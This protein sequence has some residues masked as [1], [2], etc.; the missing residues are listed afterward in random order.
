MCEGILPGGNL[1]EKLD[2]HD[3]DDIDD[4]GDPAR[5]DW[6]TF[7][8]MFQEQ[9]FATD[10][11]PRRHEQAAN[12]VEYP[13][14]EM[15]QT[16]TDKFLAEFMR[17]HRAFDNDEAKHAYLGNTEG[18]KAA[19]DA[20]AA[21]ALY[22]KCPESLQDVMNTFSHN[23]HTKGKRGDYGMVIN[24]IKRAK[25]NG[26][27]KIFEAQATARASTVVGAVQ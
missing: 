6:Q 14:G 17:Y 8:K 5:M 10:L 16:K 22:D 15:T 2:M 24:N 21:Q 27:N 12:T 1:E 3:T 18:A 20:P 13:L 9:T 23:K 4:E 25:R 7:V 19:R 26:F 11:D